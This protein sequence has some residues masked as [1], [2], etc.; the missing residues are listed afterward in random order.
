MSRIFIVAGLKA[1]L[2]FLCLAAA[3]ASGSLARAGT[4][5]GHFT[6]DSQV[7]D[8]PRFEVAAESAYLLGF[9]GNPHSYEIG[10]SF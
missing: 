4:E 7:F 9:F 10:P 1:F 6:S 3:L 5:S 8:P 2:P